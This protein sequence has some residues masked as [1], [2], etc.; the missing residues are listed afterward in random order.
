MS[1]DPSPNKNLI[2]RPLLRKGEGEVNV[3]A[4]AQER[5]KYITVLRKYSSLETFAENEAS[6]PCPFSEKEKGGI[7]V[8]AVAQERMNYIAV[9]RKASSAS[10]ILLFV[11]E[12]NVFAVAQERFKSIN[13]IARKRHEYKVNV[14]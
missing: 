12:V 7:D 8:F 2:P 6:S 11:E 14:V 5:I 1:P 3:F 9:L 10:A 13:R 4:V